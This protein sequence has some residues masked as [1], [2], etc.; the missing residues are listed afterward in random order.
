[1]TDTADTIL[2]IQKDLQSPFFSVAPKFESKTGIR[3]E[4]INY[5]LQGAF[6]YFNFFAAERLDDDHVTVQLRLSTTFKVRAITVFRK[7]TDQTEIWQTTDLISGTSWEWNDDSLLPGRNQYWTEVLLEDGTR[8]RSD[9]S[10]V[11]IEEKN[12]AILFPNPVEQDEYLRVL[13]EGGSLRFSIW[14]SQGEFVRSQNLVLRVEPVDLSDLPPG[15]Y[16]YQLE[17][18]GKVIDSGRFMKR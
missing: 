7:Y 15:V 17:R 3:A 11:F 18:S 10:E 1:M 14:Q 2:V 6:C 12:K 13:S 16:F 5:T 4:A 8:L 9:I